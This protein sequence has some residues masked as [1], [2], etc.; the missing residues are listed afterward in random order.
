[1]ALEVRKVVTQVEETRR[2]A[3]RDVVP[4]RRKVTAAAVLRN[5]LAGAYHDDLS[6]LVDAGAEV[7]ALL[8]DHALAALG[9]GT[10]DAYGKGAVV[11]VDGELEHAAAL[12]HP[13]FGAPVRAAVGG[14]ASII[15]STKKVGGPGS[16][17]V[18]PLVHRDDI[19]SFDEMDA[20]EIAIPDA[21]RA[22]EVVVCLVLARGG[23]PL[24]R[25]VKPG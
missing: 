25:T 16:A 14:G 1:M 5:P 22:D 9:S 13:R 15:P 24:A 11:G 6:V 17:I 20:A 21:P 3:G 8:V 18:M 23:R 12:L 19:W 2:D 7:A 10:V 4:H